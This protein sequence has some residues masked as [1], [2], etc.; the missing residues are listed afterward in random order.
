MTQ[1]RPLRRTITHVVD[2]L[3]RQLEGVVRKPNHDRSI[4]FRVNEKPLAQYVINHHGDGRIALWLKIPNEM[5]ESLIEMDKET[6]FVPPYLGNQGWIGVSLTMNSN[7]EEVITVVLLAYENVSG[8]VRDNDNQLVVEPPSDELDPVEFDAFN[9]NEMQGM[10]SR[11]RTF[12]NKL[13]DVNET[14]HFGRPVFKTGKKTFL[15]MGFLRARTCIE[16]WVG[17]DAQ[18][19]LLPDPRFDIPKYTGHNGW[20]LFQ[21]DFDLADRQAREL[22]LASFRHFSLKRTLKK[23]D[24]MEN[25]A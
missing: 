17:R 4:T 20:M 22:V 2:E 1:D 8:V 3:F 19:K 11:V 5:Q 23:L 15:W 13:P 10:I 14:S 21:T 25:M 18:S 6:F 12:V 7:W 24:A 9:S 16:V